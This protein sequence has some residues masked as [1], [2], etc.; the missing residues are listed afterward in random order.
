[1]TYFWCNKS[2]VA[3]QRVSANHRLVTAH[4]RVLLNK[5]AFIAKT[6]VQTVTI[7]CFTDTLCTVAEY[8]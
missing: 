2:T 3:V 5:L 1:M 8:Y 7:A 6:C 4:A